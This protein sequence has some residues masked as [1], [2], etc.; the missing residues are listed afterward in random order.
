MG[1]TPG[2]MPYVGSPKPGYQ[3]NLITRRP[4]PAAAMTSPAHEV[5]VVPSTNITQAMDMGVTP[6]PMPGAKAAPM[7]SADD[8]LKA[9][10]AP[11]AAAADPLAAEASSAAAALAKRPPLSRS[12][13]PV[14]AIPVSGPELGKAAKYL[15][16]KGHLKPGDEAAFAAEAAG[17]TDG[18]GLRALVEKW[19]KPRTGG[20]AAEAIKARMMGFKSSKGI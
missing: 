19:S 6:G 8:M 9:A 7:T 16:D 1:V 18:D 11:P 20:S 13:G 3:D 12:T 15:R 4:E 17:V 5:N 14:T 2:Q 10:S